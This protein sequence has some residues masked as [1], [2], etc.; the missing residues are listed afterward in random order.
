[1]FS[2][3]LDKKERNVYKLQILAACLKLDDV[4]CHKAVDLVL[5]SLPPAPLYPNAKVAE[6]LSGLLGEGYF[7]ENVQL[8]HNHHIG[9]GLDMIYIYFIFVY[10]PFCLSF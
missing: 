7:L 2:L 4:P 1:M 3:L 10:F 5:P 8:P 9:M 6:V